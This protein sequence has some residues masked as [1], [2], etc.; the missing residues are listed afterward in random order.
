[1][2]S[3]IDGTLAATTGGIDSANHITHVSRCACMVSA[4][5]VWEPGINELPG[6]KII[7]WLASPK[8]RTREHQKWWNPSIRALRLPFDFSKQFNLFISNRNNHRFAHTNLCL[9]LCLHKHSYI[10]LDIEAGLI[11]TNLISIYNKL[12]LLS[13][14]CA[15]SGSKQRV[16]DG[17]LPRKYWTC[18]KE[19][20][21]ETKSERIFIWWC[22]SAAK[23][24]KIYTFF[25]V[26]LS[27]KA[28]THTHTPSR[29]TKS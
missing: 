10:Y 15:S 24:W 6:W 29:D 18:G 25:G 3:Y 5:C 26:A 8:R 7:C 21:R 4:V 11:W 27:A 22:F 17:N 13:K 2:P 1:M 12:M 23:E 28:H 9:P 20:I 19:S 16:E 14:I